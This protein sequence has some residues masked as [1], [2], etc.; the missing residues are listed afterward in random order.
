MA[1]RA[2]Q[3]AALEALLVA[4][5][6]PQAAKQAGCGTRTLWRWL[7]DNTEFAAEY[8]RLTRA[9]LDAVCGR[10]R[11]A[12]G[13]ALETLEQ[14]LDAESDT[15]RCRAAESIL[16]LGVKVDADELARRV[17]ALEQAWQAQH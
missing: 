10:L 1:L 16:N 15:I 9:Q 4:P 17:E 5:S 6:V 11:L 2:K 14:L 13:K 12:S 7:S 8:R 3:R